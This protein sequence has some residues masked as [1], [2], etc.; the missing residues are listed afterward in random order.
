MTGG[1]GPYGGWEKGTYHNKQVYFIL[2]QYFVYG[3][4]VLGCLFV[5]LLFVYLFVTCLFFFVYYCIVYDDCS[6]LF[7]WFSCF[8][9]S[10][11]NSK[12]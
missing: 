9:S 3:L 5:Y 7:S 12:L 6:M 8:S 10:N 2:A 4:L 1:G 11:N